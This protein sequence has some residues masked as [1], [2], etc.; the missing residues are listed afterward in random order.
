M[1][2]ENR[3][4]FDDGGDFFQG[5]LAELFAD[6]S[7]GPALSIGEQYTSFNLLAQD[8]IFGNEILVAQQELFF[9]RARDTSQ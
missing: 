3:L 8:T 9:H 7:Q 5:L 4:R 2:G 6:F 1:P